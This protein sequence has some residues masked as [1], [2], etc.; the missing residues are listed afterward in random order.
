MPVVAITRL[1]L[2][3]PALFDDFFA[4]A[5]AA[6]EQ[7]Q[8]STGNLGADVLADADNTYWT[9]TAWQEREA[10]HAFVGSHPHIGIMSRL[11]EWC[12]EATFIDW[13]QA[14]AEMPDWQQGHARLV[15]GGQVARLSQPSDA[16]QTRDF[17]APVVP[18]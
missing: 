9:R 16:H 4:S 12:D 13:E 3:D 10:M 2:K 17:P 15:A 1:R 7:A 8:G 14:G 5:V 6:V 18:S 11:D